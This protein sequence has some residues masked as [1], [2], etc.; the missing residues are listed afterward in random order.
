MKC[1]VEDCENILSRKKGGARDFCNKHYKRFMRHGHP[2]LHSKLRMGTRF[3]TI[4][5]SMKQRCLNK[6]ASNFGR[7]GGRG[8]T[9]DKRWLIFNNFFDDMY[10][11]Y[12]SHV[13]RFTEF[14]T[15][16]ERVNNNLSYSKDNCRWAT[17]LEQRHN[18]RDYQQL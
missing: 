12:L 3:Y 7:Y 11:E 16:L 6:N 14:N 10:S 17:Y 13:K 18:R 2:G 15:T 9:L 8:I 1:K 5:A 4:W